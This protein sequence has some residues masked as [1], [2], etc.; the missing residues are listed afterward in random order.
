MEN[1]KLEHDGIKDE[2]SP[3]VATNPSNRQDET[4]LDLNDLFGADSDMSDFG[5]DDSSSDKPV[6]RGP[7]R[8]LGSKNKNAIDFKA[9]QQRRYDELTGGDSIEPINEKKRARSDS[10]NSDDSSRPVEPIVKKRKKPGIKY[11]LIR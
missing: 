7:G 11:I 4:P 3:P 6:K 1:E 8:P 2:V 5:S 9:A 10:S